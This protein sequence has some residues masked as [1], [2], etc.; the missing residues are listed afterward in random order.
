V[1]KKT[2]KKGKKTFE[3]GV[4]AQEK[5][6]KSPANSLRN[7][8]SS[9]KKEREESRPSVNV[10][11]TN[12]KIFDSSSKKCEKKCH[13]FAIR[14]GK[15]NA[16]V[17]ERERE[18]RLTAQGGGGEGGGGTS[19]RERGAAEKEVIALRGKNDRGKKDKGE[20]RVRARRARCGWEGVVT[21]REELELVGWI[22][23]E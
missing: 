22:E 4:G 6:Q 8:T 2:K 3:C 16:E 23:R 15:R 12:Y 1:E 20:E 18:T 5:E 13:A 9:R 14:D 7:G 17:K 19:Q 11:K 21:V 10:N